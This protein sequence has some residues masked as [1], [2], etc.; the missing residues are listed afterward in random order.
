MLDD[1]TLVPCLE[2]MVVGH[3]RFECGLTEYEFSTLHRGLPGTSQA[4]PDA[5]PAVQELGSLVLLGLEPA[6][7]LSSLEARNRALGDLVS[8][9]RAASTKAVR[10][11]RSD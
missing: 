2:T 4:A 7:G 8:S 5:V 6:A 3:G 11:L 1:V 9:R 10:C